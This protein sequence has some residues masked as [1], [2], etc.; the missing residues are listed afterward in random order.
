M[1]ETTGSGQ[2]QNGNSMGYSCPKCHDTGKVYYEDDNGYRFEKKCDCGY[3]ERKKIED[4]LRFADIP[5]S[6]KNMTIEN[7]RTDIYEKPESA[8]IIGTDKKVVD[9][10]LEH[11][12]EMKTKGQGFY[13]YS[14]TRGSG[15][16]RMAT[17]IANELISKKGVTVKFT[18]S[19]KMLDEIKVTWGRDNETSEH[20]LMDALSGTEVLIIDDFGIEGSKDWITERMYQIINNR[21]ISN[22]ITIFTSNMDPDN[23]QCDSRITDRIKEKTYALAFPEESIREQIFKRNMADITRVIISK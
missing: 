6:F 8:K 4:R 14:K 1:A 5:D 17:S 10:W 15:K 2:M 22:L 21:Y 9:Y 12:D 20:Q 19:L 3:T 23:L 18:T 16:T 11:F 13:F 7:F